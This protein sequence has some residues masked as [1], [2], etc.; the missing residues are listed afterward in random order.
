VKLVSTVRS[1]SRTGGEFSVTILIG[2]TREEVLV[3]VA[4]FI[5]DE[6]VQDLYR[7]WRVC[8]V[9]DKCCHAQLVDYQPVWCRRFGSDTIAAMGG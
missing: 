9:H 7:P 2:V 8:R 1:G 5:Q 3:E 4:D 6:V